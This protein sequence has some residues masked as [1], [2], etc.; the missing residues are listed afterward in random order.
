MTKLQEEFEK[1]FDGQD[2][3]RPIKDLLFEAWMEGR[4]AEGKAIYDEFLAGRKVL[5]EGVKHGYHK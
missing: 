2:K 1:W 5:M 4:E 3:T